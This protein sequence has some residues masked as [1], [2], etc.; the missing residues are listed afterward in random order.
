MRKVLAIL[1]YEYKMQMSRMAAW[2]ILFVAIGIALVDAFPSGSN[3][4]RLE[5]L[6]KPAYFISRI[7]SKNGLL[8]I[9]GIM[10]LLSSRLPID[11]KMGV[12]SLFMVASLKKGEYVLGKLLGNFLYAITMMILF[13]GFNIFVYAI[14]IPEKN[15]FFEYMLP[16]IKTVIFN[17]FPAGFFISFCAVVLPAIIDIRIFYFISSAYFLLNAVFVDSSES[18]PFYLITSGDLKKIVWQYPGYPFSDTQSILA[19]LIFMISCG[20]L[21]WFFLLIKRDFWRGE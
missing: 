19:N 2:S 18:V 13:L 1:H 16:F 5:F 12:K 15:S 8:L 4:A 10:F 20:L 11:K 21:A 7:Y 9:F 17:I 3:I 14:F 6:V